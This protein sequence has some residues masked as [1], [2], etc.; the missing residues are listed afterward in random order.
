MKGQWTKE[1]AW[2]WY[3][4]QPWIRGFNG[5]PSNCVNWVAI[6]QK[7][8]HEE[9]FREIDYEFDL[10]KKTGFNFFCNQV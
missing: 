10:A 3:N 7:Y 6:W 4:A 2:E 9:V 5:M 8:N 1:Q